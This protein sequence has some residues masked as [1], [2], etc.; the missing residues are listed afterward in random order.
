MRQ[1]L[2]EHKKAASPMA[3]DQKLS[4]DSHHNGLVMSAGRV[5]N[6]TLGLGA[7]H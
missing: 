4:F 7:L 6:P 3:H 1:T 2:N 5:N